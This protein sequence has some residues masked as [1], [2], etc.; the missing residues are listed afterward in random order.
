[1]LR[2][3]FLPGKVTADQQER[4]ID[5][6]QKGTQTLEYK[7]YMETQALKPILSDRHSSA[8]PYPA[9]R[10]RTFS[11]SSFDNSGGVPICRQP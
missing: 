3:M 10:S 4:Y 2:A 7:E 5:L 11:I 9:M 8:W 1:M 6:F